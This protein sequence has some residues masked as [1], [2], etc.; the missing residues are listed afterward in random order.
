MIFSHTIKAQPYNMNFL[1]A[2][3]SNKIRLFDYEG[4]FIHDDDIDADAHCLLKLSIIHSY[5]L[6]YC[7]SYE[8]MSK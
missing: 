2:C 1:D 5:A 6:L 4:L 8:M 3:I 7:Y